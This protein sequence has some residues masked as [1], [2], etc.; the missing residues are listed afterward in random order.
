LL[1]AEPIVRLLVD[2]RNDPSDQVPALLA[3][4]VPWCGVGA[5][6]QRVGF[7]FASG[8][9]FN[10][11]RTEARTDDDAHGASWTRLLPAGAVSV[12]ASR[13]FRNARPPR[14][15]AGCSGFGGGGSS[16]S[17]QQAVGGDSR[18]GSIR[19]V[20]ECGGPFVDEIE[21]ESRDVHTRP[22][23]YT[24]HEN[25]TECSL[26]EAKFCRQIIE[27]CRVA[28]QVRFAAL[29]RLSRTSA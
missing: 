3:P 10:R 12:F 26:F 29:Y 2:P 9:C 13:T 21:T 23:R 15:R 22:G 11:R 27:S 18:S 4:V 14:A 6:R 1:H 5:M 28:G 17:K 7:P 25:E 19:L 16:H 24:V 20:C 8:Q